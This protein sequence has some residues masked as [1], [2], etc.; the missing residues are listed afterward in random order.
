M[1]SAKIWTRWARTYIDGML[2]LRSSS[3]VSPF[4]DD[5]LSRAAQQ[6]SYGYINSMESYFTWDKSIGKQ[7]RLNSVLGMRFSEADTRFE[8]MYGENFANRHLVNPSQAAFVDQAFS[9]RRYGRTGH[10]AGLLLSHELQVP[11]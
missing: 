6:N 11:R 9:N 4:V 7:H 5:Q 3:S 10:N 8:A 2:R 1:C